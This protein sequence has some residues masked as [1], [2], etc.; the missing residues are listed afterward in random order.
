MIVGS[1]YRRV[2]V[3][4][5]GKPGQG[6]DTPDFLM[7][8]CHDD[9]SD[10]MST[11]PTIGGVYGALWDQSDVRRCVGMATL[12]IGIRLSALPRMTGIPDS[13]AGAS[14]SG[15]ASVAAIRPMLL[16]GQSLSMPNAGQ[17]VFRP[18]LHGPVKV[19][20]PGLGD[21]TAG[22]SPLRELMIPL[23]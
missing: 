18:G 1:D 13:G 22:L 12:T 8:I 15:N 3:G 2:P 6:N 19:K 11:W 17:M 9:E 23:A 16:P 5:L 10:A 20:Q 4:A 21:G 7:E 14:A